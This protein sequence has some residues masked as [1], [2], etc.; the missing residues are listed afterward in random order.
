MLLSQQYRQEIKK[1]G[2][3]MKETASD[4]LINSRSY[5]LKYWK[6]AIFE[7][8][9]PKHKQKCN[10]NPQP[11]KFIYSS[12]PTHSCAFSYMLTS[13]DALTKTKVPR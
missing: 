7:C 5:W 8:I 6:I 13:A 12:V 2:Q 3:K 9:F 11:C 4:I 1:V 10:K